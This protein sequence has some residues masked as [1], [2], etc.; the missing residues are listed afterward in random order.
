MDSF[1]I[2]LTKDLSPL[3]IHTYLN[4]RYLKANVSN[5]VSW[6]NK[7]VY[8]KTYNIQY[9]TNKIAKYIINDNNL[10]VRVRGRDGRVINGIF[11][12]LTFSA[13]PRNVLDGKEIF[14]LKKCTFLLL[15][16]AVFSKGQ[17]WLGK[18]W[19][20]LVRFGQVRVG[21]NNNNYARFGYTENLIDLKQL[22]RK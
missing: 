7:I 2:P 22:S 10:E 13:L 5:L 17:V 16:P 20:G 1:S 11:Y 4:D 3:S 15:R 6:I 21:Q 9:N 14:Q 18:F 8:R 19:L 12:T